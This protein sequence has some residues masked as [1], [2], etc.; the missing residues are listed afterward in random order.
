LIVRQLVFLFALCLGSMCLGLGITYLALT[1]GQGFDVLHIGP[2]VSAPKSGTLDIEPYTKAMMARSGQI[3]LGIAEGM[4]FTA[5]R[6][7]QGRPLNA[8]CVYH[9]SGAE[10]SA[11]VWTVTLLGRDGQ[12]L[13][14]SDH[15]SLTSQDLVRMSPSSFDI[16]LASYARPLNWLALPK[17]GSFLIMLRLYDSSLSLSSGALRASD[18]PRIERESCS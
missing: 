6:D 3:P 2:W 15:H 9:I 14:N 1:R 13:G 16:T 7:S 5:S 17:G 11:R 18:L 8:S 4:S 12:A 10:P